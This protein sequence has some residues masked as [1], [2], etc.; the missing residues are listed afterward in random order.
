MYKKIFTSFTICAFLGMA[1]LSTSC[2]TSHSCP[3][4]SSVNQESNQDVLATPDEISS[5]ENN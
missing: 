2:K 3:A 4:Y 5:E 1:L